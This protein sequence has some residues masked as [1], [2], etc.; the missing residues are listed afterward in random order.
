MVWLYEKWAFLYGKIKMRID[1]TIA[2]ADALEDNDLATIL[3]VLPGEVASPPPPSPTRSP[4]CCS[5]I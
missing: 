4:P 5:R 3:S 1:V 2:L